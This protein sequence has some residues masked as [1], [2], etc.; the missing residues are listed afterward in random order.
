MNIKEVLH[1]K[2]MKTEEHIRSLEKEGKAGKRYTAVMPDVPFLVLGTLCDIGWIIQLIYGTAYL[3]KK[4]DLLLCVSLIGVLIGVGMTVY[5][6]RIKEK[7][8]PLRYQKDLSFG[9][10]TA[11]GLIGGIAGILIGSPLVAV[12]GALNF[13]TGLPLYLSFKPGIIYGVK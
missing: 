8:M 10:T 5:L 7:E 3:F 12:G 1:A 13:A 11:A 4:F 9:L 6:N 2:R